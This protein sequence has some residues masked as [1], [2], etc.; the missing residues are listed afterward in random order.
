VL[1]K[2]KRRLLERLKRPRQRRREGLILAEGPRVVAEALAS[3]LEI[4]DAWMETDVAGTPQGRDLIRAAEDRGVSFT[5]LDGGALADLSHTESPQAVLAIVAEPS[6]ADPRLGGD[7]RV[8]LLDGVQDPGNLGT[9][10]RSAWGLGLTQV[11]IT[12]GSTDPWGTKAVRASAGAVFH[13]DLVRM[14]D[15]DAELR[16]LTHSLLVADAAGTDIEALDLDPGRGWILVVGN[17]GAGPGAS[18]RAQGRTV[19]IPMSHGMDSLNAAVAGSI[20]MY[21]LTR[22]SR[23]ASLSSPQA[24]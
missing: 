1:S 6:E 8:L 19:S 10:I 5:L 20:L 16:S 17:E 4:R 23:D 3:R 13:M 24:P 21:V 7:A 9:L 18:V 12:A 2:S 11:W 22:R 15:P 14:E